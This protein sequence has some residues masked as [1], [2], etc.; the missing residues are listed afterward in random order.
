MNGRSTSWQ[1]RPTTS[2]LLRV[3]LGSKHARTCPCQLTPRLTGKSIYTICCTFSNC[4]W[5]LTRS[6]RFV[7][8]PR[9][10]DRRLSRRGFQLRGKHSVTIGGK[11]SDSHE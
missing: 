6:V 3:W 11:A 4:E 9:R 2:E 10:S 7:L 5:I 1:E 8:T